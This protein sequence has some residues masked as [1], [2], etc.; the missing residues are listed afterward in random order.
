MLQGHFD[1]LEVGILQ[2]LL[3]VQIEVLSTSVVSE[4]IDGA[5][6]LEQDCGRDAIIRPVQ[7][8]QSRRFLFLGSASNGGVRYGAVCGSKINSC[9]VA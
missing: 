7:W 2:S 9:D 6:W 5:I 3:V 1:L 4:R 8:Q